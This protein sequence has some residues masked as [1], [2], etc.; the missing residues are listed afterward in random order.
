MATVNEQSPAVAQMQPAVELA[1][2]LLGGTAAMRRAGPTYL[3]RWPNEDEAS[4]DA[5]LRCSVLFPA[6]A[7]TVSTL[8]GKPFSKPIAF[9]ESVPPQILELTP[10]IDLQGRNLDT[11]AAEIVEAALG[12]GLAGILVDY[13]TAEGVRTQAD[14]RSAG[15]RPYWVPVMPW[16][17]LGWRASRRRGDWT[18]EQLRLTEMVEEPEGEFGSREIEQVRVLE[19][20]RWRTYRRAVKAGDGWML[21][22]EG[23]TS[24]KRVP[25][26]PIYGA[27]TGF[28]TGAPPLL[29]L[30]HLNV[31]HWQ[32]QSDQD[33]ILHVARVPVL[34]A[35]G[36]DA[37][38]FALTVGAAAAV[39][40][41]PGAKLEYVE[42]SGAAIG[43]GKTA[44]DDLKDEMRQAGAELLVIRPGAITATEVA[45][46][47]AVGMCA[48]QRIV[49]GAQDAFDLALQ[50]TAEW[51]GLPE[52]GGLTIYNDFGA[53]TLHEAS[54]QIL[55]T[56]NQSGKLSDATW[57]AE[58]QR[59]GIL[60]GELSYDD[61]RE[62][63]DA[64]GPAPGL[65]LPMAADG[66]A[67]AGAA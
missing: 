23:V 59:R 31:K 43:A 30:A 45:T 47:N 22:E 37:E 51:L 16:Q 49:A 58:M 39:K 18:I 5:R 25:F 55:L 63:L 3:P 35:I 41:P 40:L 53:A 11:F 17:I 62:R 8:T 21:H 56:A 67:D 6:Y 29:E 9:D 50:Y 33:T 42:H 1:R 2:A 20:G 24:V 28:M 46:E 27:R 52:G 61:E 66:G 38:S 13:P 7:R 4:Y 32:N 65:M 15:L 19:P 10:D 36:V 64:Q 48:L 14:A 54:A 12:Y 44:L 57:F 60:N 26:V 34:T